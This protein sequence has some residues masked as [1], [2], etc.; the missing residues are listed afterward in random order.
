MSVIIRQVFFFFFL[1]LVR[2]QGQASNQ[3]HICLLFCGSHTV[4][5]TMSTHRTFQLSM[6]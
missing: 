2:L 1:P 5:S 3:R 6:Y 4:L